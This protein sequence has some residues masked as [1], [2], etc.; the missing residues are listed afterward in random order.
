MNIF[1]TIFGGGDV[2]AKGI[3]L[4][5]DLHTSDEEEIAAK[6]KAK[7]DLLNAYNGYKVAQRV[8]AFMFASTYLLS[9]MVI[10]GMTLYQG[11]GIEG[12]KSVLSEFYI[13]PIMFTIVGFYFGGGAIEGIKRQFK[14]KSK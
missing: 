11:G 7:V 3:Q 4:I 13:G 12:M 1:S 6:A 9:F 10:T 8:L 2:I 5:D 14:N